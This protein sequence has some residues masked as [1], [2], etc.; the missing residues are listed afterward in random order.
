V[1]S[2]IP[3]WFYLVLKEALQ[4]YA[5]AALLSSGISV[6]I[7]HTISAQAAQCVADVMHEF[8]PLRGT[9]YLGCLGFDDLL[10]IS[11]CCFIQ[12]SSQHDH[13]SSISGSKADVKARQCSV[14]QQQ[15]PPRSSRA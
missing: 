12:C 9:K 8:L 10:L 4:V 3:I 7:K 13:S 1:N 5:A 6:V 2:V 14:M 11:D 15:R